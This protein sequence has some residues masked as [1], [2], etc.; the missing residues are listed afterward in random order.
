MQVLSKNNKVLIAD[1]HAIEWQ[2]GSDTPLKVLTHNNKLLLADG[3]ALRNL[4]LPTTYTELPYLVAVNSSKA[5]IDTGIP[6]QNGCRAEYK[7][8][9]KG[10]AHLFGVF[11]TTQRCRG[12]FNPTE[13]VFNVGIDATNNV[14]SSVSGLT[15]D[16]VYTV[17]ITVNPN[18]TITANGKTTTGNIDT[19]YLTWDSSPHNIYLFGVNRAD[20]DT[21][22]WGIRVIHYFKY[23][24]NNGNLLLDLIPVE[25]KSDGVLGML[26]KV[27]GQFL[28]NI[29]TGTFYKEIPASADEEIDD[30]E[31][32]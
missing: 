27:N 19:Q 24:D 26:N 15:T 28:T 21:R 14:Y 3:K 11:Y 22:N 29:S 20:I 17:N 13:A 31:I 5:W 7:A 9:L 12:Y 10:T 8:T 1:G 30:M 4:K 2:S 16:T 32:V 6:Y 23:W 18:A 25:R